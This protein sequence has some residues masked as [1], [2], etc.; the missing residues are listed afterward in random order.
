MD[1]DPLM[2]FTM[3]TY[4]RNIQVAILKEVV[5]SLGYKIKNRMVDEH[6]F[7]YTYRNEQYEFRCHST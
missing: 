4:R 5:V 7:K 3:Q 1:K 6:G 2:R